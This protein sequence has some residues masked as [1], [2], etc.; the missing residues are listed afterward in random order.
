[1][2]AEMG[3]GRDAMHGSHCECDLGKP[4]GDRKPRAMT[5]MARVQVAS[6]SGT[7]GR[8]SCSG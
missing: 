3:E 4:A 8:H 5:T 6:S 7:V 2:P 1:M